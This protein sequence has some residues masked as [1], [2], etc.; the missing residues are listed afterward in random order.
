MVAGIVR[1]SMVAR[2]VLGCYVV[3]LV[4]LVILVI[5]YLVPRSSFLVNR[6][7]VYAASRKSF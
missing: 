1:V 4:I 3:T 5:V 2:S 6:S 7:Y